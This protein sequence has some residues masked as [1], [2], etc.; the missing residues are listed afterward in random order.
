MTAK[1]ELPNIDDWVSKYQAGMSINQISK[2]TKICRESVTRQFLEYGVTLRDMSSASVVRWQAIKQTAGGIERQC[3]KAWAV[4]RSR[5]DEL[6]RE[7]IKLYTTTKISQRALAERFNCSRGN[8]TRILKANKIIDDNRKLRRAV[9]FANSDKSPII[10]PYEFD[11]LNALQAISPNV[12]HQTVIEN[13]NV[14]F[15]IG[16]IAIELERR[17]ACDSHSIVKERLEKIFGS[18]YSLIV[19]Y[20]S[21]QNANAID[22]RAVAQNIVTCSQAISTHPATFGK[23]GVVSRNGKISSALRRKFDGNTLVEFEHSG[24]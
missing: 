24:L 12:Q 5:D 23:Y 19:V 8:I 15:T 11:L 2:Q 3:S 13:I 10:S 4:S 18:G 20:L 14:D 9:G 21:R 17:S 16:N 1:R 7:V 22:W 6:E